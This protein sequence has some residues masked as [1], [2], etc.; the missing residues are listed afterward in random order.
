[1]KLNMRFEIVTIFPEIFREYFNTSIIKRARASRLINIQVH[2]IRS[3]ALGRHQRADDTPYGGGAGM[4]MLAEPVL[5]TVTKIKRQASSRRKII[6]FSAKGRQLNQKMIQNWV[7]NYKQLILISGR[8]E[9]I[10]ERVRLALRAEE[11]A[12]GPFVLTDGDVPAMAVVSA[13]TR[14]LPGVIAFASLQEESFWGSLLSQKKNSSKVLEYPHYT[15]PEVIT[16][17]KKKYRVPK[18]LLSGN[19]A[20]I[21]KWRLAQMQSPKI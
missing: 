18:V 8:Y 19:H 3:Q 21:K 20:V 6:L 2:D 4:V 5:K 13:V 14:L 7:K 1:M 17:N 15:R 11:V 9:G 16:Y 10:D 12:L